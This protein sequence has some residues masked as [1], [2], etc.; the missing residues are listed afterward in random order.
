M[1][2]VYCTEIT[3]HISSGLRS[4]GEDE[5]RHEPGKGSRSQNKKELVRHTE[6][7]R[8]HGGTKESEMVRVEITND[9]TGCKSEWAREGRGG[10]GRGGCCSDVG[11]K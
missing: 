9:C 3:K 4:S 1:D 5:V 2:T 11:K 10:E 6:E 8:Y 7:L